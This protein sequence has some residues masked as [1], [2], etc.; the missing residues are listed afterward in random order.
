MALPHGLGGE[1]EASVLLQL[2]RRVAVDVAVHVVRVF[3]HGDAAGLRACHSLVLQIFRRR[4]RR[5]SA[6]PRDDGVRC[7]ASGRLDRFNEYPNTT[8]THDGW[9]ASMEQTRA[10]ASYSEM[11]AASEKQPK[12]K[13]NCGPGGPVVRWHEV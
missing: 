4:T 2:R 3:R 12:S 1:E 9:I 11:R 10:V 6:R 7:Y 8:A 13:V 5:G